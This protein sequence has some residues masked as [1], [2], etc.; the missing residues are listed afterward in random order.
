[1]GNHIKVSVIV[2]VYNSGSFLEVAIESILSQSFQDIE[3]ILVDDGSTDG[4]DDICERYA[5]LDSRVI[6][7]HQSNGGICNARNAAIKIAKGDY[8]AFCDHDDEF[9][10]GLLENAYQQAISHNA[11]IV[12]YKKK[13]ITYANGEVQRVRFSQLR[14]CVYKH[15]NVR[16]AFFPL[17]TSRILDCVWDGIYRRAFIEK[18]CLLFDEDYKHGGEDVDLCCR[19]FVYAEVV[20]TISQCFYHHYIRKGFSTSSKF[21]FRKTYTQR[22][23]AE[24][25]TKCAETLNVL[26]EFHTEYAYQMTFTAFNGIAAIISNSECKLS[27][28]EKKSILQDLHDASFLPTWVYEV[29]AFSVAKIS[30]KYGCVF[31]LF[32]YKLYG[33]LLLLNHMK[34]K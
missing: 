21:N 30:K 15:D 32:K 14:D 4:S 19:M 27:M 8:L 3:L 11:D 33:V 10:P 6:V 31:F 18:H 28:K 12:K 25:I 29:S 24:T 2:P 23:L 16:K 34:Q 13:E 20:V 17:L 9:L 1:M 5:H 7:I 22:K 26:N